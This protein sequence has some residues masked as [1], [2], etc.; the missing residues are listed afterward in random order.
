MHGESEKLVIT[1]LVIR[2]FSDLPGASMD[3]VDF[4]D[5]TDFSRF[6][7]TDTHLVVARMTLFSVPTALFSFPRQSRIW[8]EQ[9]LFMLM[10][11]CANPSI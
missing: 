2:D 8:K 10:S 9:V 4:R 6:S 7:D 3:C 11:I 5:P 1:L